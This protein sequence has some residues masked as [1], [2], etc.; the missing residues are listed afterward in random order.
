VETAQCLIETGPKSHPRSVPILPPL[1]VYALQI[2]V[3][4]AIR[5]V[6]GAPDRYTL[7]PAYLKSTPCLFDASIYVCHVNIP[8]EARDYG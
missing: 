2:E 6:I 4:W 8:S 5:H 1:I 7:W 3:F